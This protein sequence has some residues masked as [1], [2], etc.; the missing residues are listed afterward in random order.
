MTRIWAAT[1]AFCILAHGQDMNRVSDLNRD[2]NTVDASVRSDLAEPVQEKPQGFQK[3]SHRTTYSRW[4]FQT[5]TAT[6]TNAAPVKDTSQGNGEERPSSSVVWPHSATNSVPAPLSNSGPKKV[7]RQQNSVGASP[8]D[9]D[10]YGSIRLKPV[11]ATATPPLPDSQDNHFRTR[12]YEQQFGVSNALSFQP[13]FPVGRGARGRPSKFRAEK[14]AIVG[15]AESWA[16]FLTAI[17]Q[18]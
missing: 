9:H 14:S 17:K 10:H 7:D 13:C 5:T 4:L 11:G 18:K 1:A 6:S 16:T 2:S 3:P 15:P 8:A 12:P